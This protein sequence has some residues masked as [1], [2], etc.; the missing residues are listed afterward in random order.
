M[1]LF[2]LGELLADLFQLQCR[3]LKVVSCLDKLRGD[4]IHLENITNIITI[5]ITNFKNKKP[6]KMSGYY[7]SPFQIGL[8][9]PAAAGLHLAIF[10]ILIFES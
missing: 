2:F 4:S 9:L 7:M 3:P 5:N 10:F 8:F 6:E 1:A